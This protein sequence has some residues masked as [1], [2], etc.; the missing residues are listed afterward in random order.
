MPTLG[1]CKPHFPL[2]PKCE[3]PYLTF[4]SFPP[5]KTGSG[6]IFFL[7]CYGAPSQLRLARTLCSIML[8]P[9][10]PSPPSPRQAPLAV[11]VGPLLV[12]GS[13][14]RCDARLAGALYTVNEWPDCWVRRMGL[15]PNPPKPSLGTP[16]PNCRPL[17][18]TGSQAQKE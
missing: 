9:S 6:W 10:R 16:P 14:G 4:Q 7:I 12:S 13:R 15:T 2:I 5:G 1:V 17:P 3:P 8:S 18:L 11:L